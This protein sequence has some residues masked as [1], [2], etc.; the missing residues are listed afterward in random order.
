M[1]LFQAFVLHNNWMLKNNSYNTFIQDQ[2]YF[3]VHVCI[4][5]RGNMGKYWL[6]SVGENIHY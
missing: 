3:I 2:M 1:L 4:P 6:F 5:P